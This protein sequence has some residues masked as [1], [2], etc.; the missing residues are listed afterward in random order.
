LLTLSGT[1]GARSDSTSSLRVQILFVSVKDLGSRSRYVLP[2]S[3]LPLAFEFSSPSFGHGQRR[4]LSMN[5]TSGSAQI[6]RTLYSQKE[7]RDPDAWY[8]Q[9]FGLAASDSF[10]LRIPEPPNNTFQS[11]THVPKPHHISRP[12]E[13]ATQRLTCLSCRLQNT[14]Y[15]SEEA[16]SKH[17]FR[18]LIVPPSL[19]PFTWL[20]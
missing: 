13:T 12:R 5:T 14:N 8:R 15:C 3:S 1:S 19:S 6:S 7:L 20:Q 16:P 9:G 18:C 2:F 11:L 10:L 17:Q 4:R